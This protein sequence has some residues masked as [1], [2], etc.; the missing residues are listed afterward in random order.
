MEMTAV[1][2]DQVL[3]DID[4]GNVV[5]AKQDKLRNVY[6][7]HLEVKKK[8]AQESIKENHERAGE[9]MEEAL[10]NI[11][12]TMGTDDEQQLLDLIRNSF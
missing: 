6:E 5:L 10:N 8:H 2:L 7:E 11:E 4:R 1:D 3:L 9:A 12:N